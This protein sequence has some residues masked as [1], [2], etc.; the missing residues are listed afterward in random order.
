MGSVRP[1]PHPPDTN[2]RSPEVATGGIRC[3]R[4]YCLTHCI[5]WMSATANCDLETVAIEDGCSR[6]IADSPF[7]ERLSARSEHAQRQC[8]SERT[9]RSGSQVDPSTQL[10]SKSQ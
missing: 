5:F 2:S 7:S 6:T 8:G 9:W 4:I 3:S 1:K 10:V